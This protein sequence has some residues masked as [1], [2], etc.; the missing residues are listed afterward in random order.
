MMVLVMSN[1]EGHDG[2][3]S[4]R[5]HSNP[6][7]DTREYEIEYDDGTTDRYYANI[8]AENLY[9]QVDSEGNRHLV[10]KE[11]VD[12][13]SDG[14]AIIKQDGYT[15]SKNGNKVS[16]KTTRGWQ[17]CVE[18][19]DGTTDWI[20]LKD[21]RDSNPIEVEEYAVAN[22][23]DDEPAFVWWVQNTL[24]R[25]DRIISNA[26]TKYWRTTHKFGIRVPKTVEEALRI[27]AYTGT[28]FWCDD[29]KKEMSKVKI[30]WEVRDDINPDDVHTGKDKRLVGYQ[31]I[32]CHIIF[33]VKMDLSRKARFVAGGHTTKAPVSITYSSVVSW[34]SVR[35][36]FLIAELNNLKI[37]SCD[38]GNTYLH[39]PC[40]EKI[41]FQAGRECG[42]DAGE[43]M[44]ITRA[45][46]GLSSTGAS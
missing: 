42:E 26:K 41:W 7:F 1:K 3:F 33:N 13:K 14:S 32:K 16:K 10:F 15:I 25:R 2:E 18:W 36:A 28:H 4:G 20:D 12:H 5:G 9:S 23:I 46:Y 21:L 37:F 6:L 38:V 22:K 29:I 17:L 45:L 44:V 31:E 24:R 35:L 8:I 19:R 30:A 40:R 27:D 34:D 43:L 39:A 11:M